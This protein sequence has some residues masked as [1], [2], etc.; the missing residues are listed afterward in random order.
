MDNGY[1]HIGN[2]QQF[3]IFSCGAKMSFVSALSLSLQNLLTKKA[4]TILVAAAGSI[5]I[6]GI[7]LISA[8]ST[9]FQN[10]IDKIEEDT[11][12]SYPLALQK[13]SVS[14]MRMIFIILWDLAVYPCRDSFLASRKRWTDNDNHP[15]KCLQAVRCAD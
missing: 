4:R 11:L 13:E 12:T 1:L 7:A 8:V 3:P 2:I 10:Y 14:R 9:G 6:I 5:G 15:C